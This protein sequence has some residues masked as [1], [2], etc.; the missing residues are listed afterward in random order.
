MPNNSPIGLFDSG[1]GGLTVAQELFEEMPQERII[2]FGDTLHVPYGG[3]K[4]EEIVYY[5]TK[6]LNFMVNFKIKAALMACN[7][8]SAVALPIVRNLYPFPIFGVLLPGAEAA[9]RSTV[10]KK[11]GVIANVV[12][13]NSG[14]YQNTLLSLDGVRYVYTRA[15]PRLVPLAEAGNVNTP[16]SEEVLEEYLSPLEKK[17]IDTLILGCTHYPFFS[18]GI[19]KIL[20]ENINLIDPGVYAVKLLKKYLTESDSIRDPQSEE[21]PHRFFVSKD[22][23]SFRQI[24]QKLLN[25]PFPKVEFSQI[26]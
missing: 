10:N 8:S 17:D 23:N 18:S 5:V 3:K 22:P 20:G 11:I 9:V 4:P 15:C 26:F 6:I 21:Y 2:Y 13:V 14:V 24:A 1:V 16:F 19:K 25:K 12:T 7:T